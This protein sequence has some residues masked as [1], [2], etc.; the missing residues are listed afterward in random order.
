MNLS[1]D[2]KGA[3]RS[4]FINLCKSCVPYVELRL[5]TT[6][7]FMFTGYSTFGILYAARV[8]RKYVK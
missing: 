3:L 2:L 5:C 6:K 4:L 8:S 1:V 7:L